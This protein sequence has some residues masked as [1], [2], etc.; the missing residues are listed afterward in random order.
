MNYEGYRDPTAEIAIHHA[1]RTPDHVMEIINM[2]RAIASI[3]G[4]EVVG[5]IALK[6]KSTGKEYK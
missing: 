5:R 1:D 6:D 2:M 3:A 4:F